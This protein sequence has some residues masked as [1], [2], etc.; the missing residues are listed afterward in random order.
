MAES[1][2][3]KG[4]PP[5]KII[6]Q[7]VEAGKAAFNPSTAPEGRV[8][9]LQAYEDL[10]ASTSTW[11][12]LPALNSLI[13]PDVLPPWL[14]DPLLQALT[15]L[16][17][18]PDGVRGTLEFVFSVHPSTQD[19]AAHSQQPQKSGANITHEAVAVA[20]RLLSTVPATLSPDEW[21]GGIAPQLFALFDGDAGE[22]LAKTAAQIVG[23][24]ILGK[25][26]MGA[27]G[28]AGWNAFVRPLI[29]PINYSLQSARER[30]LGL[31]QEPGDEIVHLGRNKILVSDEKLVAA[32]RRLKV[33]VLSNPSPGLCRR[34]LKPVLLQL[35]A[36]ASM[37]N[38]TEA[39]AQ[40]YCTPAENL[41][42][43]Y[44]T[45]FGKADAIAPFIRDI[46]CEGSSHG[47]ERTWRFRADGHS[48]VDVEAVSSPGGVDLL[49]VEPRAEK[50]AKLITRFCSNEEIS[51]LFLVLLR[52][53]IRSLKQQNETSIKIAPSSQSMQE[54]SPLQELA[55]LSI[56]Q[57][58]METAPDKLVGHFDQLMG[59]ICQVLRGNE[60]IPLGDDVMSVI[61]SLLNLVVTATSFRRSDIQPR[62][63]DLIEVS[64]RKIAGSDSS[65]VSATA[66]NL[67]MLLE[68]RDQLDQPPQ[69]DH[70]ASSSSAP[71]SRQI[72]DRKTYNLAMNYITGDR[73]HPPPVVSEGL[74][75]LSTL[76]TA[77]SPILDITAVT[78]LMSNLLRDN[79]DY[80]N[81]RV[82]KIFTQL[83][84]KHPKT[85]LR[86]LLENYLDPQEQCSTDTR[87][88]FGEALLQVIERL[89]ETFSGDM[90]QQ[91]G[92]TLLSIAGRRAHRPKTQ[93]K[94]A[95]EERLA[96][97]KKKNKASA[98]DG[99]EDEREEHEE[100]EDEN[101]MMTETER[102]NNEIL[103]QIIQ[104]WESK[105]GSEDIRMRASALSIFGA[106]LE[107]N[108]A[109]MGPSLVSNAVDL[110]VHVLSV[111]RDMEYAILRR[112]AILAIL[113]FVR[114][115][116]EA[117][118]SGRSPGFGLTMSSR[119][120][121]QRTLEYVA[122]ADNDGLVQQHARDV[123]ESLR[124]W[125]IGSLLAQRQQQQQ[126]SEGM[127]GGL[128]LS[129]SRLAGLNVNVSPE[130]GIGGQ[131]RRRIE[132]ID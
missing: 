98:R 64:L 70:E 63:M 85:T 56:L 119:E 7:I 99:D 107:V 46:L 22:D 27:P 80:I 2:H 102:A 113:G 18:R 15:R 12:L 127:A 10:V 4:P 96:K 132:E 90:A 87:L 84:N 123:V 106:A 69:S 49:Q 104:G 125:Q 126:Q 38:H 39:I 19:A 47:S 112:A 17:L 131:I 108:I 67:T 45:L 95:R 101:S 86:E 31:S 65:D 105:R 53:W 14:R 61:L 71:S 51:E 121:I 42:Q 35:W 76:I 114:A 62:D 82:I 30:D 122:E 25:K 97:M 29:E 5:S 3:R 13:K 74:S 116:H 93:A 44:F 43:T 52:N 9:A 59:V 11:I 81:L 28:A 109:G 50:L 120:D 73:D 36:L 78:V 40:K 34:V 111:E 89:G 37:V 24:G 115:L 6:E 32:V 66:R 21:Y 130:E 77:E 41:L 129:L 60:Q 124:D 23:F 128:G 92:E 103:A 100:D 117:R 33:L 57:K 68:Y 88:R 20:T 110:C 26:Q 94:Q 72:E 1:A 79:E 58:L 55:E 83:A 54:D 8:P 48:K 118:Q 75:M 91:A 16:P